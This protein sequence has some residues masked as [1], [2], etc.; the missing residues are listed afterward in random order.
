M[1]SIVPV[2][3]LASESGELGAGRPAGTNGPTAPKPVQLITTVLPAA[4]GA[5]AVGTSSSSLGKIRAALR[6]PRR[7]GAISIGRRQYFECGPP[8]S[9][10]R[11]QQLSRG[12]SRRRPHAVR[13][14][15]RD[16]NRSELSFR[17]QNPTDFPSSL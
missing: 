16:L 10:R 8:E 17:H 13:I 12:L 6:F 7:T 4:A 1:P 14:A 5:V 2:T 15:V 3:P 9:K 11:S